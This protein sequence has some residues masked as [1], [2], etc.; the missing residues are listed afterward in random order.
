[1]NYKLIYND[2][3]YHHGVKGMKWG[4][5]KDERVASAIEGVRRAKQDYSNAYNE[6]YSFSRRHPVTQFVKRSKNYQKSNDLWGNAEKKANAVI[7]AKAKVKDTKNLVKTER[8][9][10]R[11]AKRAENRSSWEKGLAKEHQRNVD[12]LKKNGVQSEAYKRQMT[13]D[14][15]RQ[16]RQFEEKF[17]EDS[18]HAFY[19][20]ADAIA[21]DHGSK[22]RV[23]DLIKSESSARNSHVNTARKYLKKKKALME[24]PISELT[25][26]RD[27]RSMYKSSGMLKPNSTIE[28]LSDG[29]ARQKERASIPNA[30][31]QKLN[32]EAA[33]R[34]A[35]KRAWDERQNNLDRKM[36]FQH[37]VFDKMDAARASG[38]K[39]SQ[40]YYKKI[41][42][43][44][45]RNTGTIKPQRPK[46]KR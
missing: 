27:V 22:Q 19:A 33:A 8:Y 21:Y 10:D 40:E 46:K 17:G 13:K 29:R 2:E 39:A 15:D 6:A 24:M 34:T 31:E 3:L 42:R 26:K 35:K 9:R 36:K 41:L 38:D 4:V 18:Y 25:T 23:A 14:L 12:D 7:D 5:R 16:K 37:E 43:D 45:L 20:W 32:A 1:M 11:L 30:H 28:I 44:S